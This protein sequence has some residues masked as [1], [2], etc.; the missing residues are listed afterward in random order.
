MLGH[1]CYATPN[2]NATLR[3]FALSATSLLAG[4]QWLPWS[5][6]ASGHW[7]PLSDPWPWQEEATLD[8]EEL[9]KRQTIVV[10]MSKG[11]LAF[12]KDRLSVPANDNAVMYYREVL[13]LD[14]YNQ[15][16]L[17]GLKHVGQRYRKLAITAHEN[18]NGKQ[19]RKYLEQAESVSGVN[20]K[21]NRKL[22]E[23]LQTTPQGQNQ[24]SLSQPLQDNLQQKYQAQKKLI[25]DNQR[26]KADKDTE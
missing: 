1:F 9:V 7:S 24:R 11:D 2:M 17:D 13:K 8:S 26:T 12:T 21:A 18:G 25:E 23:T 3:M 16:A 19:A 5:Q 14:P 22:R 15:P 6:H 20:S 10:L 4:C